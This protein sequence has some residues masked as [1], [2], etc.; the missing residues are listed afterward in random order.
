MSC[1]WCP[2]PLYT[3]HTFHGLESQDS[4]RSGRPGSLSKS[5][6]VRENDHFGQILEMSG[7]QFWD[8]SGKRGLLW[9]FLLT[10]LHSTARETCFAQCQIIRNL[11]TN[12]ARTQNNLRS[13]LL[14]NGVRDL[15]VEN[16]TPGGKPGSSYTHGKR[17]KHLD[18][19]LGQIRV[20]LELTLTQKSATQGW[21]QLSSEL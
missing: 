5:F 9:E 4:H 12:S 7:K 2:R 20:Q 3:D 21:V 15:D 1:T 8:K 17:R 14:H 19:S 16:V 10:Q 13:K 6:A 11:K 18:C